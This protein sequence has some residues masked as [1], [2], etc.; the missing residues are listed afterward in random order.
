MIS[1]EVIIGDYRITRDAMTELLWIEKEDSEAMGL[2]EKCELLL[3][4]ALDKFWKENF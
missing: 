2:S 1:E 3:I 4:E